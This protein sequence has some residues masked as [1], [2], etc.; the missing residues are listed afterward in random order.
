MVEQLAI[1][2]CICFV[3]ISNLNFIIAG[4]ITKSDVHFNRAKC[5]VCEADIK[6]N[7][8]KSSIIIHFR[9]SKHRK[10]MI[11]VRRA[12]GQ[13]EDGNTSQD[14]E[15][16][17]ADEN[18]DD[19]YDPEL[20]EPI[21]KME[22]DYLDTTLNFSDPG[23]VDTSLVSSRNCK[24]SPQEANL[25]SIQTQTN[26]VRSHNNS[27]HSDVDNPSSTTSN[28]F[29]NLKLKQASSMGEMVANEMRGITDS[30]LLATFKSSILQIVCDL[31]S[32]KL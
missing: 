30:K 17:E 13:E 11:K 20:Q 18:M 4:I 12:N 25:N 7:T 1:L 2:F 8:G 26:G 22:P 15:V 3:K 6:L 16:S 32:G 19:Y 5:I 14:Q 23:S 9:S 21:I 10:N 27:R 24:K 28:S 31:N 29:H